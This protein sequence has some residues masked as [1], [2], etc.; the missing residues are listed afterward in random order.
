MNH[1]FKRLKYRHKK[2]INPQTGSCGTVRSHRSRTKKSKSAPFKHEK[3][4]VN[5][6]LGFQY[7]VHLYRCAKEGPYAGGRVY[8]WD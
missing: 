5:P 1:K 7:S 4:E 2:I 6:L 3:S 8:S